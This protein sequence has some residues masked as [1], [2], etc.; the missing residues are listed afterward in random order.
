MII[1][2]YFTVVLM[3]LLQLP[4]E[5]AGKS[6]LYAVLGVSRSASISEIKRA[7]RSKARDTHPDKQRGVDPEVAA[8]A[9]RE[10]VEAYEVLSDDVSRRRYDQTGATREEPSRPQQGNQNRYSW[11]WNFG[12]N[13]RPSQRQHRFLYEPARRA[14]IRDAQSRIINIRS[15]TQLRSIISGDDDEEETV[16]ERYV[17]IA[18]RDSLSARCSEFLS[19]EILYPWPFAGYN[20]EGTGGMWWE[21]IM[22]AGVVDV[23]QTDWHTAELMKYFDISPTAERCPTII[24]ISRG[25]QIED[26]NAG[27]HRLN[28]PRSAE[29]FMQWVWPKL[30]MN[31]NFN[32]LTPYNIAV[33]WL[34]GRLGKRQPDIKPGDVFSMT[35]FISHT[36]Y[37]RADFVEGNI[38][39]NEV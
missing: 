20:Y 10:I 32:N 27:V 24:L 8:I 29:E 30:K 28:T 9:F 5:T 7:Y 26:L 21:E 34:D 15:L 4:L 12:F 3:S 37:L 36:F 39:T 25:T 33:W 13:S 1:G 11:S 14:H 18:F 38:L 16:T 6:D 17:M 31:I 19:D 35:T 2:S 22:I 23:S